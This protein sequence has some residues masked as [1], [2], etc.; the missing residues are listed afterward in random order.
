MVNDQEQVDIVEENIELGKRRSVKAWFS[1][2]WNNMLIKESTFIRCLSFIF[3]I[4][5]FIEWLTVIPGLPTGLGLFFDY[6]MF[7]FLYL[8][9]F[10][11]L[12]FIVRYIFA[13]FYLQRI[14]LLIAS[15]GILITQSIIIMLKTNWGWKVTLWMTS[16]VFVMT[17]IIALFFTYL[18]VVK[19]K[20]FSYIALTFGG[21]LIL[22]S[23][24]F[25]VSDW[26]VKRD[27]SQIIEI[28]RD[29]L[30]ASKEQKNDAVEDSTNDKDI[31]DESQDGS[32]K[33]ID[34][35]LDAFPVNP[36]EDGSYEVAHYEYR[37][38]MSDDEELN[39]QTIY[40]KP[41]DGS[42]V[43]K[44]WSWTKELYWKFTEDEIPINGQVWTPIG[45]GPFPI[46]FIT[47]GNHL[48][49]ADSSDGYA[50]LGNLLASHG[51]I[52]CSIDANFLNYS[53]WS[54]IV[55]DDQLLRSWLMLAQ[56]T[57]FYETPIEQLSIDWL[58]VGLIGHSRGGQAVAMAV[59]AKKWLGDLDIVDILDK[60]SI[61]A[62]VG[63]APTDYR[64][65]SKQ[66]YL[67]NVNYLTLHGTMDSDLVE[68]FG[69]RQFERT[70]FNEPGHFKATVE[71]YHANHGQFNTV[72]GK[73]DEK[74]PGALFLNTKDL[75]SG[76][77]QREA[78]KLFINSFLLAS[79][80]GKSQYQAVFEDYRTVGQYLPLT[81]YVTRYQNSNTKLLFDFERT[82]TEQSW[83]TSSLIQQ[84][85]VALQG[86]S[87]G[88]KQNK[89]LRLQW[90]GED[91]HIKFSLSN[92]L[93]NK[94][95]GKVEAITLSVAQVEYKLVPDEEDPIANPEE[96]QQDQANQDFG[97]NQVDQSTQ[98]NAN[99]E[100]LNIP[101]NEKLEE[102][103]DYFTDEGLLEKSEDQLQ[104]IEQLIHQNI[105]EQVPELPIELTLT[106][107]EWG[108]I[109]LDLSKYYYLLA[110]VENDFT[111]LNL[112]EE[113]IKNG[114]YD[115][116]LEP[117][118]QSYTIPLYLFDEEAENYDFSKL[119]SIT[120]T[121]SSPAGS[122]IIDNIG[123]I[124]EGGSYVD[125]SK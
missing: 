79:L 30:L 91:Q 93:R 71:L 121:F 45:E 123:V 20:S 105:L 48:S 34:W 83:E 38:N 92:Q 62:V 113:N 22:V 37:S 16:I 21:L 27:E 66:P 58:Q 55:D 40:T 124:T 110:P 26:I 109:T 125:F 72:W 74:F 33:Q 101:I 118:L 47:H 77:D 76:E 25:G 88:T 115:V 7:G 86:R 122:L 100:Q 65:D 11:A 59:D 116:S 84:E 14:A 107:S 13:F 53:V 120:L 36:A 5:C 112:L 12:I 61:R 23:V 15:A 90:L 73:Y 69:D 32:I 63:I 119:D 94:I 51:M 102:V 104:Q 57:S 114:K 89:A 97:N 96:K 39:E 31:E 17:L 35:K 42:A 111:K 75:M 67:K 10:L 44:N 108:S 52:V 87:G 99:N 78:A 56:L 28:Y 9:G 95:N 60:I 19:K 81:G 43:L 98:S 46:V 6:M 2:R 18:F 80:K 70:S 64:V 49:E 3:M 4:A 50:Y 68:S 85:V 82:N 103:I 54:G 41:M 1:R 8:I 29:V 24:V 117:L 106:S